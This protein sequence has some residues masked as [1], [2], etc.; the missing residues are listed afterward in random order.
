MMP[1]SKA[2]PKTP[3]AAAKRRSAL[4][5]A[6]D[7]PWFKALA[8]PMRQRLFACLVK[9]GRPCSVTEI[10][11]CCA[12]DF[13]VVAR[14]LRVLASAG[15]VRAEKVGRVVWY[16]AE[17]EGLCARLEALKAAIQEWSVAGQSGECCPGDSNDGC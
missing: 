8:E 12:L 7:Q 11:E 14:H 13:S 1:V 15:L 5:G 4:D 16:A 17:G 6:L 9:C 2:A 10:A 3:R